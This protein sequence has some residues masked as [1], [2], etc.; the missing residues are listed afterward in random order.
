MLLDYTCMGNG[1]EAWLEKPAGSPTS[2]CILGISEGLLY[3]L[4]WENKMSHVHTAN[5][6]LPLK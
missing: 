1:K 6:L 4:G 3:S 2:T 5:C